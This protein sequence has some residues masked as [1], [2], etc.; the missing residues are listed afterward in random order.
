MR[1]RV[2]HDPLHLVANQS[3]EA[4]IGSTRPDALA[5]QSPGGFERVLDGEDPGSNLVFGEVDP[6]R[7]VGESSQIHRQRQQIDEFPVVALQIGWF[8]HRFT[9]VAEGE[10]APH[11]GQLAPGL[12]SASVADYG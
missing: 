11:G 8:G 6:R 10:T 9:R 3:A 7:T 5:N 12:F 2:N 4:A 1:S